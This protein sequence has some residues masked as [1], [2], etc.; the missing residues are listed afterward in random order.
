MTQPFRKPAV[1]F[2]PGTGLLRNDHFQMA[3][4][5]NDLDRASDVFRNRYGIKEFR[6]LAGKLP[7]G[8]D[9]SIALAWAGGIM[10][11]LMHMQGPGTAFYNDRL[12]ADGF[13][14][15]HHHLGYFIP[16]ETAWKALE[17]EI[18]RDGWKVALKV[19]TAGFLRAWYVETPELDHYLEYMYLEAGGIE[20]F[21]TVPSS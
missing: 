21:N 3:Y 20:F 19:D 6:G 13:A 5:T 9:F 8:G 17:H 15:R 7:T 12:P 10:F 16:D 1:T 4:V 2:S 14:I 18:E 11:E